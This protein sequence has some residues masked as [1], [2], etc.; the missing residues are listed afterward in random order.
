MSK[1]DNS[2]EKL[3]GFSN[4]VS[5]RKFLETGL[6]GIFGALAALALG[7]LSR[8]PA[9]AA[10][11]YCCAPQGVTCNGCPSVYTGGCPSGFNTCTNS[12]C[13][14]YCWYATGS[15]NCRSTAGTLYNCRDCIKPGASCSSTGNATNGPCTCAQGSPYRIGAR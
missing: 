15:W 8:Q 11:P 3:E 4:S 6:K 5:R 1:E 14:S 10:G 9:L 12:Q 7:D 2:R 13:A